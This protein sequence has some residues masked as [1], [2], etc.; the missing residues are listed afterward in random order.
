MGTFQAV[1]KYDSYAKDV[2]RETFGDRLDTSDVVFSF[3]PDA[4]TGEVDGIIDGNIAVEIGV[5]SPKQVRASVLDLILHP[6]PGKLLLLVDTPG[7]L[8]ERSAIQAATILGRAGC[9]GVVYRLPAQGDHDLDAIRVDLAEVVSKYVSEIRTN[10]VRV[11]D[12]VEGSDSMLL[13][14]EAD[15]LFGQRTDIG[16]DV[17]R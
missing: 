5:G 8:T 15:G 4:G 2:L 13:F 14:D 12:S 7:H 11:F 3:G 16:E 17:T 1:G 10:L 6:A 9:S